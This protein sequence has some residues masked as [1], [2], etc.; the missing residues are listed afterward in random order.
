MNM[1]QKHK[2]EYIRFEDNSVWAGF[3]G[4]TLSVEEEEEEGWLGDN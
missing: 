2:M 4:P 1:Y 3:E